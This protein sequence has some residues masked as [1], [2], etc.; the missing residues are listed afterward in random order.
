MKEMMTK[1]LSRRGVVTGVAAAVVAGVGGCATGGATRSDRVHFVL[2]HGAWH[3]AWCWAKLVP[4]L[5]E[6]GHLVTAVDLPGRWQSS[7]QMA[8]IRAAEFAETVGQVVR[9]SPWPVVL[10]GHSL[11]G[12]SISLAAEQHPD[13]IR[14]LVYLAAFLVPPGQ[15]AGRLARGDRD[16]LISKAV[17]RDSVTGV[18]TIDPAFAREVFYQDCSEDDVRMALQLLSPEP[19]AISTA[20]L[21]LT[22]E[23]YGRVERVYIECLQDRAISIGAQRAMQAN[24]KCKRVVT[25]DAS[26][27][28]FLSR[29]RE[30]AMAL[31]DLLG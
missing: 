17:R 26:H 1:N 3:G 16:S 28:P 11:G 2:V 14:C 13:R 10:V 30:L 5:R 6:Q 25:M 23:R 4:L 18:S 21:Q 8:N 15:T 20:S 31:A 9:S 7:G 27:S 24:M 19:P 22:Q 29:P 12:V